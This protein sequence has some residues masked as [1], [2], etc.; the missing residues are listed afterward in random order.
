MRLM[1]GAIALLYPFT[2]IMQQEVPENFT[3]STEE[4][5]SIREFLDIV[6]NHVGIVD[7]Q[8]HVYID[9]AFK[10]RRNSSVS[11][12]GLPKGFTET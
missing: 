7:W 12:G 2:L 5:Y 11:R 3:I 9:S 1:E 4:T 10:R 6:F 8:N